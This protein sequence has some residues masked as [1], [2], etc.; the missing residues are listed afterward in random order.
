MKHECSLPFSREPATYL[1]PDMNLVHIL[2]SYFSNIYFNIIL[3]SAPVS[4]K[5]SLTFMFSD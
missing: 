3:Q 4:L 1:Y 5:W 2:R